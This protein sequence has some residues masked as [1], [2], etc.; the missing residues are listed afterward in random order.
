MTRR[1]IRLLPVA[2]IL[3]AAPSTASAALWRDVTATALGTKTAGW[4]NK[5]ELADLD[6]DGDIDLLFANGG[7]YNEPGE[8]DQC[9]VWFNEGPGAGGVPRFE[10]R[11]A[12]VLGDI[13]GAARVIK[14]ADLDGDGALDLVIGHT[15]HTQ[16]RMLFGNGDGTFRDASDQLPQIR[17]SVGDIEVGDVDDDGDL[18]LVLS[19]W[20]LDAGDGALL[21]PF[22]AAGGRTLLWIND[23][24]GRFTD[25]TESAMPAVKVK[26]SWEL[27]L[28]DVDDDFD[29]D[30]LVACKTCAGSFLLRNEGGRF[31]HVK[32]GGL[33]QFTNN[34]DFEPMF[35]T[36]PGDS[37]SRLA[38][39]TINDGEQA[40]AADPN[41]FREHIF[42]VGAA[43]KFTDQSAT[44]FPKKENI[45][46]DDN[47]ASVLDFDSDGDP[48]FLIAALGDGDDRL[49][50]NDLA[51]A[52]SFVLST[53]RGIETGLVGTPGTL[54][55]A[56][57]DLNGDGK[58][59]VVQSQGELADPEAVFLGDEIAADRA[60][61]I[62]RAVDSLA[63]GAGGTQR[64]RAR[65]HD[66]K[67]PLR[68][69]DFRTVE[70][71]WITTAGK[72]SP[73]AM[74]WS[75]EFLFVAEIEAP[76][77]GAT[78]YTVC[79]VDAAGNE[80]CSEPVE[81]E[82]GKFDDLEGEGQG[83]SD[84]GCGCRSAGD[85]W[86]ASWLGLGVMVLALRRRA[87]A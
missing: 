57:A 50:V 59:D 7:N 31:T 10:D 6:D 21:D 8:P 87:R 55:I 74:A 49:A 14:A 26:W 62:V 56:T 9:G 28:V 23:G 53:N 36:L 15:Y 39:V 19:D 27:D 41:S 54:G 22:T 79:A 42:V 46:V 71:R 67:S 5:V 47:M 32:A 82:A 37:T 33:P 12:E 84:S 45:G 73:V 83:A 30:V 65:V 20:G 25:A 58:L 18:D 77:K 68:P 86:R 24:A 4:T 29:L 76:P 48:D 16:S 63:K 44:L 35:I 72:P 75:G 34:Y 17:A 80:A 3:G 40:D 66:N 52:G 78:A 60:P 13:V 64:V 51:G 81:L 70:L 61:P 85:D 1:A 69:H 2:V 43:G 38:V 11:S